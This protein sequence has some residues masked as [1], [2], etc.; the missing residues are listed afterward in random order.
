MSGMPYAMASLDRLDPRAMPVPAPASAAVGALRL[1]R[2]ALLR[3]LASALS[4][5][6]VSPM[7]AIQSLMPDAGPLE[8]S[9]AMPCPSLSLGIPLEPLTSPQL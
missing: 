4:V 2:A 3:C 7:S 5:L 8:L 1:I 6:L 9:G